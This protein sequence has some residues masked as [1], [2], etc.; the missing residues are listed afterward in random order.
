[1]FVDPDCGLKTRTVDEAKEQ[2]TNI[3]KAVDLVRAEL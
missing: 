2:L 3:K 1:M